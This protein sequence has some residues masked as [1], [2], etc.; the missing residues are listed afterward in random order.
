[1]AD[2][3]VRSPIPLFDD[4][5]VF[6]YLKLTDAGDGTYSLAM[7]STGA[8]ATKIRSP[9]PAH[10]DPTLFPLIPLVDNGDGTYSI[11]VVYG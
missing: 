8:V 10:S 11:K 2:L 3:K 9:W 5:T 7:T 4:P 6:P 1:M